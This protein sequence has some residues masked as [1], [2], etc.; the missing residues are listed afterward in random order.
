MK[1]GTHCMS[2]CTKKCKIIFI[3]QSLS[4]ATK[5]SY[6]NILKKRTTNIPIVYKVLNQQLQEPEPLS[7]KGE[8]M[9][10]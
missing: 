3:Y 9:T 5:L 1:S 4:Q 2:N 6:C 10:M 7:T 8:A